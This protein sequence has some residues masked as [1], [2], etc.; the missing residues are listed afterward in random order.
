RH[1]AFRNKHTKVDRACVA[2]CWRQ[3]PTHGL[4]VRRHLPQMA[5]VRGKRPDNC[6]PPAAHSKRVSARPHHQRASLAGLVMAC[7][8]HRSHR[9]LCHSRLGYTPEP[10]TAFGQ[11]L[12]LRH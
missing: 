2:G 11:S 12:P 8:I 9:A 7:R 3:R 5:K 6:H 4:A 1:R 10:T